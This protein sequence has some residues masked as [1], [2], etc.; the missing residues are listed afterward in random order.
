[1]EA[2][3]MFF[4]LT[5]CNLVNVLNIYNLWITCTNLTSTNHNALPE[6]SSFLDYAWLRLYN[7]NT[8]WISFTTVFPCCILLGTKTNTASA[9]TTQPD[10]LLFF[11]ILEFCLISCFHQH[12]L[13][14]YSSVTRWQF[15]ISDTFVP[16]V[17][18]LGHLSLNLWHHHTQR[19]PTWDGD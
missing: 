16:A 9:D 10:Y 3:C 11:G 13:S 2:K 5:D 8:N 17:Q 19:C 14:C 18:P 6:N 1:M 4:L 15:Q 12:I 7:Y